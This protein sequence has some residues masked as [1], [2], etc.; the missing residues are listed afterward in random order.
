MHE[1][2]I[3]GPQPWKPFGEPAIPVASIHFAR[4]RSD[5]SIFRSQLS[6]ESQFLE[7]SLEQELGTAWGV[8]I[9]L[10]HISRLSGQATASLFLASPSSV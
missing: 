1:V 6:T 3:S 2:I 4:S 8:P 7:S 5:V 9:I 10:H